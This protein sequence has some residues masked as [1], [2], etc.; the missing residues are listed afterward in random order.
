MASATSSLTN[1]SS[2]GWAYADEVQ[3]LLDM[4]PTV[5]ADAQREADESFQSLP[6]IDLDLGGSGW[7]LDN[8]ASAT[9]IIGV[10]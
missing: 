6:D 2:V 3:R 8:W 4:L 5:Q 10:F 1:P 9:S 7:E